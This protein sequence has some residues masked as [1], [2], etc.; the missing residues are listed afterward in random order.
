MHEKYQFSSGVSCD[1]LR[2]ELYEQ[3]QEPQKFRKSKK[4]R[5]DKDKDSAMGSLSSRDQL[6]T[7]QFNTY[8][9]LVGHVN[10]PVHSIDSSQ[11]TEKWYTLGSTGASS[12]ST[13]DDDHK[14]VGGGAG[15]SSNSN[16][17][18]STNLTS[19]FSKDSISIRIKAKYQ[20]VD[21]LPISCYKRLVD[22]NF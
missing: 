10:R 20:S 15:G 4:E 2:V 21:I 13:H 6:A 5:G 8:Y 16:A 14:S 17:S 12:G 7:S 22:V 1:N 9:T 18:S 3:T 11:P 19:S